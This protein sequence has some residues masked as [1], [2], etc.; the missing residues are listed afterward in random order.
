MG[1]FPTAFLNLD[2]QV[3]SHRPSGLMDLGLHN[4]AVTS[5]TLPGPSWLRK[6]N[7]DQDNV[8]QNKMYCKIK[9]LYLIQDNAV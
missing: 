3:R 5:A 4:P 2:Q 1:A 9:E 7:A 6:G 8:L